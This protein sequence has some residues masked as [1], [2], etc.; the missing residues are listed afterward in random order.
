MKSSP[1]ISTIAKGAYRGVMSGYDGMEEDGGYSWPTYEAQIF[2]ILRNSQV[3]VPSNDEHEAKEIYKN[4]NV[5]ILSPN[6][7]GNRR[8]RMYL[9][10]IN[11]ESLD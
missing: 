11:L 2:Y 3:K 5:A 1:H 6:P 4:R 8:E 7:M 9:C 10:M